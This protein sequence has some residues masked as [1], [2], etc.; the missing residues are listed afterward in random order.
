MMNDDILKVLV[1]K[2]E[3]EKRIEELGKEITRDYNGKEIVVISVLKG[4]V[5]FLA[6]IIREIDTNV[7]MDFMIVSSFSGAVSSGVV[8]IMRDLSV[9]IENKD[10]LIIEDILDSGNTLKYLS[11]ILKGR[12]P[13]SLKICTM[14][15]KPMRVTAAIKPD[16]VGF[17]IP[18]EYVVGMGLDYNERY[19]NLPYIG[20]LKPEIYDEK[21]SI[22]L[23]LKK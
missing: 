5:V 3:L 18:D 1:T 22:A 16:Y 6:D 23:G 9:S 10:V 17:E 8:R 7:L 21:D 20:V 2:E 4:A 15:Y 11:D 12:N 13:A 19:R 14:L